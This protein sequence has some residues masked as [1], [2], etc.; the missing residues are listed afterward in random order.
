MSGRGVAHVHLSLGVLRLV[1]FLLRERL[2]G[3]EQVHDQEKDVEETAR[4]QRD[5]IR[6]LGLTTETKSN[7]SKE[8]ERVRYGLHHNGI[9]QIPSENGADE[10]THN[11]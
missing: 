1:D 4:D 7:A 8:G 11:D 10:A 9:R 5:Q 6:R 2:L 3:T